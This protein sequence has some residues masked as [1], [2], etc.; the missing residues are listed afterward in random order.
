MSRTKKGQKG[1]GYEYWTKRPG[2][3]PGGIPGAFTK[4]KT[5]RLERQDNKETTK[6]EI[7]QEEKSV[8]IIQVH[9]VTVLLQNTGPD[10]LFCHTNLPAATYPFQDNESVKISV[11]RGRGREYAE[12]HFPN[13]KITVKEE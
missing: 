7:T 11:A 3:K 12:Q 8:D 9:E 6:E 13:C 1:P 2:N 4:K 10:I 5:H